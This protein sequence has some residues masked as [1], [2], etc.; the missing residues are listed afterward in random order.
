MTTQTIRPLVKQRG[1]GVGLQIRLEHLWLALVPVMVALKVLLTPI[2]PYDFWWHLAYGREIVRSGTLPALDVFSYTRAGAPYFDQPWLAQV[3]MYSG[4]Q[5]FGATGLQVIQAILVAGT[6]TLLMALLRYYGAGTR[7]AVFAALL[8]AISAYDNWQVRPQ[9]YALPL[10]LAAIALIERWRRTGHTPWILVPLVIVW[11]N[12][13]GTFTLPL[14]LGGIVLAGEGVMTLRG[15]GMRTRADLGRMTAVLAVATLGTLLNPH[16]AALW[17]YV[18]S[19]LGNRAVSELVTEW[20]A[21][22]L[23]TPEGTIFFSILAV[24]V[25]A[26]MLRRRQV[27]LALW[28][29][30]AAWTV[31]ALSAGRNIIWLGPLAAAVIAPLWPARTRVWR[32]EST[33]L[34]G[35]LLI[36]LLLPFGLVVP[37]FRAAMPPRLGAAIDPETPVQAVAELGRLADPPQRLFHDNGF[38]SYLIWELPEQQVFVDPR[39]EHYPLQQWY[40]YVALSNGEHFAELS[41]RYDFDGFLLH[42]THQRRLL[43]RLRHDP[44]WRVTIDTPTAV[45]VQ[46]VTAEPKH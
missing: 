21:P 37:P 13:H 30:L 15:T 8:A 29:A 31:L 45:L 38:G 40:D 24:A 32:S 7:I 22:R 35:L 27:P 17:W 1:F 6:Y 18:R 39:I 5:W 23:G 41:A 34:N 11:A 9:T 19:L 2:A 14:A 4:Y 33:V 42:P 36:V 28:L 44:T 10:W 16:G 25:I 46:P 12:L 20:A 3:L 43:E 26:L